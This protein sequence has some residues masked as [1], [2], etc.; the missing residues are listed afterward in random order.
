LF[1]AFLRFKRP[2]ILHQCTPLF[3]GMMLRWSYVDESMLPTDFMFRNITFK[4][5]K[6]EVL[7]R[8]FENCTY[9]R[10]QSSSV[11]SDK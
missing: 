3:E 9:R 10:K 5:C 6:L 1:E 7:P 8:R 11:A 4:D 2:E